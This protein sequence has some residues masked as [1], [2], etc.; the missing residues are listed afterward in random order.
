MRKPQEGLG[1]PLAPAARLLTTPLLPH[2]ARVV[3]CECNKLGFPEH[4]LCRVSR[5]HQIGYHIKGHCTE[6]ACV[7]AKWETLTLTQGRSEPDHSVGRAPGCSPLLSILAL[8]PPAPNAYR[9]AVCYQKRKTGSF[10]LNIEQFKALAF[11][12]FFF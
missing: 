12:F 9:G 1:P 11:S 2:V 7:T 4:L 8:L 10:I 3:S 6:P 5:P